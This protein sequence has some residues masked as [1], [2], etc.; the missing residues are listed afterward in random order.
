MRRLARFCLEKDS[1]R[2]QI[3]RKLSLTSYIFVSAQFWRSIRATVAIDRSKVRAEAAERDQWRSP[4]G[5][6]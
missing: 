5:F 6:A 2:L 4:R 1:F 3:V